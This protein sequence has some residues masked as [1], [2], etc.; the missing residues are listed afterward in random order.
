MAWQLSGNWR[1]EK[2]RHDLA[3]R[4]TPNDLQW[5]WPMTQRLSSLED[6]RWMPTPG[7]S[8]N[9]VLAGA[10]SSTGKPLLANDPHLQLSLPSYWYLARIE[11]PGRVLTR[12]HRA[13]RAL[14]GHRP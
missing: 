9:W 14:R 7:A 10:L 2:L 3:D 12:R 4:L 11:L 8:N 1:D 5:I 13:R 6:S